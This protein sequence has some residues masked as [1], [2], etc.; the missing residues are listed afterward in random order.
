MKHFQKIKMLILE[1]GF[2]LCFAELVTATFLTRY[3]ENEYYLTKYS[4]SWEDA[5]GICRGLGGDLV[6]EGMKKRAIRK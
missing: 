1:C 2:Y 6:V 4:H 5:R 3:D